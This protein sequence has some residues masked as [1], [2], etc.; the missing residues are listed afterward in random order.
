MR[1]QFPGKTFRWE[2][3]CCQPWIFYASQDEPEPY[4]IQ[5]RPPYI[6]FPVILFGTGTWIGGRFYSRWREQE[7]YDLLKPG[8]GEKKKCLAI[9]I[10]SN[11]VMGSIWGRL[12]QLTSLT[13]SRTTMAIYEPAPRQEIHIQRPEQPVN[14]FPPEPAKAP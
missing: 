5:E 14:L 11:A 2:L 12:S 7:V 10:P 13:Q 9:Y 6:M 4:R 1:P 8:E 3:P